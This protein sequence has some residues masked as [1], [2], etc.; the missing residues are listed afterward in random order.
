MLYA[1][2]PRTNEE[3]AAL[4]NNKPTSV[5]GA[6]SLN[7]SMGLVSLTQENK[8]E[9]IFT[10]TKDGIDRI[11]KLPATKPGERVPPTRANPVKDRVLISMRNGGLR[12]ADFT[13][14]TVTQKRLYSIVCELKKLGH[15]I[16]TKRKNGLVTYYID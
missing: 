12:A 1:A 11:L 8:K 10:I 6:N 9:A 5:R 13:K 16:K 15:P 14:V 3:L 4:L 7:I 2:G